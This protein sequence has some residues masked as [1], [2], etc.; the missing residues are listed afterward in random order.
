MSTPEK[1]LFEGSRIDAVVFSAEGDSIVCCSYTGN[2]VAT[3]DAGTSKLKSRIEVCI[4]LPLLF[5]IL[6]SCTSVA[7]SDHEAQ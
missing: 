1:V 3:I 7:M 4:F 2:F 6:T 5:S